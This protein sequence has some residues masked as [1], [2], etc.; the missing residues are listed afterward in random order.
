MPSSDPKLIDE[1]GVV[2]WT[3]DIKTLADATYPAN[4]AIAAPYDSTASYEKG[5]YCLRNGLLYKCNTPIGSGGEAWNSSH[6]DQTSSA[7]EFGIGGINE[8]LLDNWYFVGGGSQ[9]GRGNFP[10][11]QRGQT[12][13][14]SVGYAIDRWQID[15]GNTLTLYDDYIGC[16]GM[17]QYQKTDF[18]RNLLGKTLTLTALC[19]SN[20]LLSGT[21]TLP[22][23][24]PASLAFYWA[25]SSTLSFVLFPEYQDSQVF[26]FD[27]SKN[28]IA[29]KLELGDTQTLAHQESGVWV[30]NEIPNYIEQLYGCQTAV[31]SSG[32]IYANH[33]TGTAKVTSVTLTAANWTGSDPYTQTVSVSGGTANSKVDLQPTAAQL[34]QLISDGVVSLLIENNSGTFT[35]YAL[36]AA[37]STDMT[38]QATVTEV[39]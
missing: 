21:I 27:G 10:I 33:G 36:G 37:T 17:Y 2:L 23:A 32:D 11:N 28:I 34:A 9:Q 4:A 25:V 5:D 15:S 31:A 24:F 20:E 8:N 30:L 13:Y 39:T 19:S 3:A 35:A 6:W 38:I 14:G 26:R 18:V 12:T 29:A 16:N 1:D 22:N 7:N